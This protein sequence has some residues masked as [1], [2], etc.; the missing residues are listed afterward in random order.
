MAEASLPLQSPG[1][2]VAGRKPAGLQDDTDGAGQ[3][4]SG[5]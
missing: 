5:G 1:Q 4:Y 3:R 2:R